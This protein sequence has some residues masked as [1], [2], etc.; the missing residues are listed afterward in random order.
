[1]SALRVRSCRSYSRLFLLDPKSSTAS[2][3]TN[4]YSDIYTVGQQQA[5]VWMQSKCCSIMFHQLMMKKTKKKQSQR[6]LVQHA[7]TNKRMH[8]D[9][10]RQNGNMVGNRGLWLKFHSKATTKTINYECIYNN[11]QQHFICCCCCCVG[12][13]TTH[14]ALRA[15]TTANSCW[16]EFCSTVVG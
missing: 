13:A 6:M 4:I 2:Y 12:F 16:I 14:S 7:W 3:P 5:P 15:Q 9:Y 10:V 11:R 1:M 8:Y